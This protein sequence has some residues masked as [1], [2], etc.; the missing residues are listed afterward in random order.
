MKKKGSPTDHVIVEV[1]NKI[2]KLLAKSSENKA[3]FFIA[4][5]FSKIF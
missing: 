3:V 2:L 1:W 4:L 5:D